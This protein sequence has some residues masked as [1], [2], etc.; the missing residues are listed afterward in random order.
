MANEKAASTGGTV[1]MVGVS[2]VLILGLMGWLFVQ[3]RNRAAATVAEGDTAAVAAPGA[4][5]GGPAPSQVVTSQ[6]F[7]PNVKSYVDQVVELT[8]AKYQAG[9]SPQTFWLE[10]PSGAP[11]LVKLDSALVAAGTPIPTG[12]TLDIVGT[13]RNKD[14]ATVAQWVSAGVRRCRR[15]SGRRISRPARF[16]RRGSS[17]L[18]RKPGAAT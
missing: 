2:V 17:R 12:G 18:R 1:A 5:A 15:N 10:L 8:D 14:A 3:E 6:E 9:L 13:V 11:F 7:E 4:P 16:V